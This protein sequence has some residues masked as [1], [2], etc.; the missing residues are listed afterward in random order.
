VHDISRTGRVL[1]T[2]DNTRLGINALPPGETRE[3]SLSWFDW[4]L[5]TDISADGKAIVFSESGAAVG[6]HYSVLMRK[7][8]GSPA[9]RLGDGGFGVLSPDGKWVVA[10]LGSPAKLMLLP[11]GPGEPRALTGDQSDQ[12]SPAW[13][14]DSQSF[15]FS[16]QP[17]G[18]GPRTYLLDINGGSP[19]ALTPEGTR[20][21]LLTPDG[22]FLLTI[23]ES[24]QRALY[25]LADGEPK[26]INV[27][28]APNERVLSFL[29]N[30]HT[31]LV[32]STTVPMHIIKL[33]IDTGKREPLKD[34]EPGDL[35][36]LKSI[37]SI[38]FSADG[39]S[40][41]YSTFRILSD[42]YVVS[43]LK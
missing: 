42:L 15:V 30:S 39:K 28:I 14:P 17:S 27:A 31:L 32:A 9:I 8:D 18:H 43:G 38:R 40:Y 7:T 3:R 4:S 2:E 11:T 6:T 36:G 13:L 19:R 20:G 21:G 41:A 23:D 25:P 24:R 26:K 35:A 34:I 1:V 12:F 22:H 37:P 5:L 29:E 16:N 10:A 33:D